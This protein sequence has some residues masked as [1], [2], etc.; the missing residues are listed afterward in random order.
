MRGV[1]LLGDRE[2]YV[3]GKA[4]F[5]GV[6]SNENVINPSQIIGS[7]LTLMGS[8][9]LSL[10]MTWEMVNFLDNQ[11]VSF[12][13]AITHRFSRDDASEKMMLQKPTK[14]LMKVKLVRLFLI[15][16]NLKVYV[17]FFRYNI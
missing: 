17:K 12:E 5:V 7:Q 16:H 8:F 6:G 10:W 14:S 11:K 1:V 13:S 3:S 9:V 15:G 2:C 4:V